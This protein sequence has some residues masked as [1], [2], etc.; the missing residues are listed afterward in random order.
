M[1]RVL[2]PMVFVA[3]L[4]GVVALAIP[5]QGHTDLFAAVL[6]GTVTAGTVAYGLPWVY[7]GMHP[8]G[9]RLDE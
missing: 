2:Q 4:A 6:T 5:L 3:L 8:A 1:A 7:A 9:P